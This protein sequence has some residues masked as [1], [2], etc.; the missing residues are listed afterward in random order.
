MPHTSGPK[1][2]TTLYTIFIMAILSLLIAADRVQADRPGRPNVVLI[3][4]DDMGYADVGCYGSKDIRTPHIDRLAKDGTRLTDFYSAGP[5]CTPTRA[6]LMTGRWQQR[7]GLEWAIGPGM[8]EPGLPARETTVARLL[9]DAGYRTAL[10]GKWHLGYKKEFGPNVHGFDTHVGLLSGNVDH[11]SKK[12][13]NGELDWYHDHVLQYEPGYA[14]DL[15]TARTVAYVDKH[16]GAPF[17]VYVAYNAV[18]W[19]FQPPDR[20]DDVRTRATW[21]DGDRK[22]YAAMV[23]RIDAGVGK[24]VAALKERGILDNTLLVFTNDNG[25]ERY[26]DNGP[27]AQRKGTLWE[28]GIRVPCLLRW[29]GHVAA[30]TLSRQP[31]ISM[32]LTATVLAACGVKPQEGRPLDGVDLLPLLKT[33]RVTER[34]FFWRIDRGK[35]QQ[36]A[37]RR[38][39]WKYLLAGGKERLFDLTADPGERTSLD[40]RHPDRLA[41]LRRRYAA[42]EAE[43]A[44]EKPAFVVK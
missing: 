25:G 18:H 7:V 2:G 6:A 17:F 43:M 27:F 4:T 12:E 21:F 23:E 28:G 14:T 41:D 35:V 15:I 33:G 37:V 30:G 10:F 42:W 22:R 9:R 32:D 26:S 3:M 5:V 16:A 1:I 36:K 39:D 20:P 31:A 11:Y 8:K 19:P 24:I 13:I 44:K 38:G 34:T 40:A 29:P